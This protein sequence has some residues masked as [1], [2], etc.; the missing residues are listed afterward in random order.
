VPLPN[1]SDDEGSRFGFEQNRSYLSAALG[2][3][4]PQWLAKRAIAVSVETDRSWYDRGDTVEMTIDFK[5]R[6]PVPVEIETPRRRLWGWSIDGTLEATDERVYEPGNP[7]LFS[8]RPRERKRVH[9]EW[10]GRCKQTDGETTRWVTPSPNEYEI[11]AF[12]AT[13]G[14]RP[15]D[16]TTIEIT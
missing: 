1:E 8:F 15:S 13:E 3:L 6:L 7:G 9:R 2:M 10:S 12:V 16:T 14:N 5:N 11:A 4:V